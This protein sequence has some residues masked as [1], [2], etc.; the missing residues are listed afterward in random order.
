MIFRTGFTARNLTFKDFDKASYDYAVFALYAPLGSEISGVYLE[1]LII[2]NVPNFV[3]TLDSAGNINNVN[4]TDCVVS[5]VNSAW[6]VNGIK[7]DTTGV[8]SDINITGN[9]F[10][11]IYTTDTTRDVFGVYIG[12]DANFGNPEV[13]TPERIFI[14]NNT[15]ERLTGGT[16]PNIYY[17]GQ[18]RGI[19]AYGNS[20]IVNKNT[21]QNINP[22]P[23]HTGIYLKGSNS[24]ITNNIVH[25][26]GSAK[27]T[28]DVGSGD[29]T[30]KGTDNSNNLISGN[31]ITSDYDNPGIGIYTTGEIEISNNYVKKTAG[32]FGIY[33]YDLLGKSLAIIDNYVEVSAADGKAV[34]I[35]EADS[36]EIAYNAIIH[37]E[38]EAIYLGS[39]VNVNVHDNTICEGFECG[40]IVPPRPTCQNQGYLCCEA[41][42]DTSYP[43]YDDACEEGCVCCAA[44]G[45]GAVTPTPSPTPDPTPSPTPAPAPTTTSSVTI[46]SDSCSD[47]PPAGTPDLFQIDAN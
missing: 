46:T 26:G 5:D 29:I 4:I 20:I 45:D 18:A 3:F 19:I 36:G 37:Y 38:G 47:F 7:I 8:M 24:Q 42:L 15:L 13:T 6:S 31:K 16:E 30:I 43:T 21:I 1:N 44:C 41:C 12:S 23:A 22:S 17:D 14:E 25:N 11:D 9:T 28:P 32:Y 39:S 2:E 40:T 33:S 10:S 27:A 34:R 35:S